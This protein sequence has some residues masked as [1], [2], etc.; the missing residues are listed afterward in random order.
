MK[1]S[2]HM[3]K[4]VISALLVLV[5]VAAFILPNIHVS[6]ADTDADLWIDPV[7]GSD[8]NDGSTEATALKTIQAAKTKAAELSADQDVVVILKSGTYD[9]TETIVFGTE[10]SGKNGHTITYRAA[11]GATPIISGGTRLEGWT[12][13]DAE[14][15]I[16]VTD[17]PEGTEL[18]RSFYVNGKV[19]TMAYIE[20]SPI[21]WQVLNTSGYR[22]PY[23]A[24]E[25]NHEY[26][27]MDLGADKLVSGLTLYAG[28]ERAADGNA[29][30]FPK[31]FTIQVSAD[32]VNWTTVVTETDAEAPIARSGK[33]FI[34]TTVGARYVKL[35]VTKLGNAPRN[36]TGKFH[37]ALSEI[38]V[39]VSGKESK[40]DLNLVQHLDMENPTTVNNVTL[41]VADGLLIGTDAVLGAIGLTGA[42]LD[43]VRGNIKI[44]TTTDGENW[45]TVLNKKNYLFSY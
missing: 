8:T 38:L 42:D 32:G 36:T 28:S 11:S 29:A 10:D 41:S 25:D 35:D 18:A 2:K 7:N 31:D 17:I 9:A 23:V 26:L 16:Y 37:L 30:G 43:G 12:L 13:H 24:S 20:Q 27:I 14:K 22:S 21:D 40:I 33:Q 44:E 6:A 4:R 3:W 1:T 5:M 15:N 39:G 45:T 34:F 19:Q